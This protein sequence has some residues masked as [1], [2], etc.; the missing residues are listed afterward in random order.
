M[1]DTIVFFMTGLLI[2]SWRLCVVR[3]GA[4]CF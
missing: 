1:V 2:G 4:T 3:I